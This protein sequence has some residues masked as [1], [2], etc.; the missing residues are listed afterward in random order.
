MALEL[1]I[2]LT[3]SEVDHISYL[4]WETL[5]VEQRADSFVSTASF[6][7]IDET[8]A[9]I[10]IAE[11]DSVILQ[12][13]PTKY[14]A[15]VVANID[16]VNFADGK[17][18]VLYTISCQDYN[19]LVE[20]VVIDQV[21]TY[22]GVLD[23][24]IID[25]LFD[26]YLPE[27]NSHTPGGAP[28]GYVQSLHVFPEIEFV[29]CSLREALDRIATEVETTALAG[30]W[31][32]DYDKYLHYFNEEDNSPGWGLSDTPDNVTTFDYH[33]AVARHRESSSLVNRI[34]IVGADVALLV[35]DWD[36]YYYYGKWFEAVVRD[37]TLLGV[38]DVVA[39][40]YGLLS[41]WA[42]PDEYF[43]V[44]T[45]KEGLRA[46]MNL[47]FENSL[48]GTGVRTN[49]CEN[50]SFEN[51]VVDFWNFFQAGAG[52]SAAQ[53][54]THTLRGT[55][56]CLLTAD[57]VDNSRQVTDVV[58]VADGETITVHTNI[59]REDDVS[60][61]VGLYDS[62]NAVT[63]ATE[64]AAVT[65]VWEP[66]TL[67]WT[68][69]TGLNADVKLVVW[70]L[71][72]DGA[73]A[74]WFDACVIE[75]DKGPRPIVYIDG[76]MPYCDWNGAAH[77]STS[78]RNSYYMVKQLTITW[79]DG[80]PPEP[81]FALQLG[82]QTASSSLI[83]GRLA[84][85]KYSSGIGPV[86]PGQLPICSKGWAHDLVFSATD[87]DTVEWDAGAITTADGTVYSIGAGNTGNMAA[88]TVYY[89]YLDVD[90]SEVALQ[91]TGMGPAV[92]R[93]IILVAVAFPNADAT[94]EAEFQ[95]FGGQGVNTFITAD[96]IAANTITG[97]EIAANTITA[98]NI[99]A[100]TITATEIAAETI[101]SN[102]I[103]S[104]TITAD[105]LTIGELLFSSAD[106]LLL[107]GP[108]NKIDQNYWYGTRNTL[109]TIS[110]AFHREQGRWVGTRGLVIERT[111]TNHIANPSFEVDNSEWAGQLGA[112]VARVATNPVFGTACGSAT[113]PAV[114]G[115]LIYSGPS[116]AGTFL[117]DDLV[118][119][120]VYLKWVSGT[121]QAQLGFFE[122]TAADAW[123]KTQQTAITLTSQWT[124]YTFTH[125]CDEATC[126]H[127]R[128]FIGE[129]DDTAT[130]FLMDAAQL[131]K[132][133]WPSSYCDGSLGEGY[134][135][136]G[137]AHAS[138]STRTAT[139]VNLDANI[140][141]IDGKNT[142]SH[143]LRVR[144][145]FDHDV[146]PTEAG[147]TTFFLMTYR[148]DATLDQVL[149]YY[150]TA[151]DKF[152]VNVN[153][154]ALASLESSAQTFSEGDEI[155]F[156]V[157]LDYAADDYN[158]YIDGV[159]EDN[160]TG[161]ETAPSGIDHWNLG[162]EED[163]GAFPNP[164]GGCYSEYAVFDSILSASDVGNL[165]NL[166][167]PLVDMAPTTKPGIYIYDGQFVIASSI[168]GERVEITSDGIVG[169]N[170]VEETFILNTDGSGQIGASSYEP[171]TWDTTGLIAKLKAVQM[172]IGQP[173]I[174][175]D[176]CIM[177]LGPYNLTDTD[178]WLGSRGEIATISGAFHTEQG[179]W[180]GSRALVI[181]EATTNYELAPRMLDDDSSGF[182]DGWGY[183]DN[184]GSGGSA[185]L[186]VGAHPITER[187][188]LQR[189]QYT[190]AAGDVDDQA[191]ITD[192]TS[193]GS[194][195][196]GDDVTISADLK[197]DWSG[198]NVRLWIREQG[199]AATTH[200]GPALTPSWTPKRVSFT[201]TMVD[202]GCTH[203]FAGLHIYN[204]DNGDEVDVYF[205]AVNIEKTDHPTSFCCGALDWC[206][207][208]G[209]ADASTSTR[210]ATEVNLDAYADRLAD[211]D[212]MS[213]VIWAQMPY[214]HD[215]AWPNATF[216]Y[217]MYVYD[218]GGDV[219]LILAYNAT[220]E[221]F[222]IYVDNA[223]VSNGPTETFSAGDWKLLVFTVDYAN[224]EYDLYIDGEL[225]AYS[226][227]AQASGDV[228]QWNLGSRYNA[229]YPTNSTYG[230]YAVLDRVLEP[231]EISRIWNTAQAP[232]DMGSAEKPGIYILDGRFKMASS[233]T[234][235]RIEITGDEIAGYDSAGT[236][237][238]YI[239]ASDGRGYFG[240]GDCILDEDGLLLSLGEAD[241]NKVRWGSLT[242]IYA[243]DDGVS[244]FNALASWVSE[245]AD[246]NHYGV[247]Y[248]GALGSGANNPSEVRLVSG[249]TGDNTPQID[250]LT[251][252][253]NLQ[254]VGGG[255]FAMNCDTDFY[256][257][258]TSGDIYI[259]CDDW[260]IFEVSG[261]SIDGLRPDVDETGFVGSGAI[262]W[263]DM[264]SKD[265]SDIGCLGDFSNGVKI[266]PGFSPQR[267]EDAVQLLFADE[268]EVVSALEALQRIKVS[269]KGERTMYDTP[270]LDYSTLPAAAYKPW[271]DD[272]GNFVRDR[273]SLTALISIL[274]QAVNELTDKVK[275]LEQ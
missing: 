179:Y 239:Q 145:P 67:S 59:Y 82:G 192:L 222:Q 94:K 47:E 138:T 149:L 28:P 25:D 37:N 116:A 41:K 186:T 78:Y 236:K 162:S 83:K 249:K 104:N 108:A 160:A 254:N 12:D 33:S 11:K 194:F 178:T 35:Q 115:T 154:N 124:R 153:G 216:N 30:Y 215:A 211:L 7:L 207:W 113:W 217:F 38:E 193:V 43:E 100:G 183:W 218:S 137:T 133:S 156:V 109:G 15:G 240:G 77:N 144:M 66:I 147:M 166:Q 191:L 4:V 258:V 103:A 51:N 196:Q 259:D 198:C 224:D 36:S 136:A 19:I 134:S 45:D 228:E 204:V 161:A 128:M 165:Y 201:T 123:L 263:Y 1:L 63:R 189:V 91:V 226:T 260:M 31:Y 76:T 42:F 13:G 69:D 225:G 173:I 16:S 79:P 212:T 187:G 247:I 208:S 142:V 229:I 246:G 97:N 250:I 14:F 230:Y 252:T 49:L 167:R 131:E 85:D 232:V 169:Y 148:D 130:N 181:E 244:T 235:N 175:S 73:S 238:F 101:T 34:L 203:V 143:A 71:E 88:A 139:Y 197:G 81:R 206:S 185:T 182:A 195:A 96:N 64:D 106:G 264:N 241:K 265:F 55:Q 86:E 48:F 23:S 177:L 114:N 90:T 44:S 171:I 58:T 184:F 221:E 68:N 127:V 107:F 188:W 170:D 98:G 157:T 273:A 267:A 266:G 219:R 256:F 251:D 168:S 46:G 21:E 80:C 223:W 10:Q 176:S 245:A 132:W 62:T 255:S 275:E 172:D 125:A 262:G 242:Y 87:H 20:E 261:G 151:D 214:D 74:F 152:K 5:T 84:A 52:G 141:L 17:E 248:L 56:A 119:V 272:D 163:D 164:L 274:M 200:N 129:S 271:Y 92:G 140:G 122:Y 89:I 158:L 231:D 174:D 269:T 27:I 159:L 72:G 150:N 257:D 39:H 121:K 120:S 60:A 3:G 233:A 268:G 61:R 93:N 40:G 6:Q 110:G 112:A 220:D 18:S 111:T 32:I 227:D 155:L 29:D 243:Y 117:Q 234:G 65:D 213:F 105:K 8:G 53:D 126:D 54:N 9:A 199:G 57:D 202:A 205:G 24:T 2:G 180:D 26:K 135:W 99:Q 210:T 146:A 22:G 237:Q 118:S 70:N 102:E 190:G 50:P 95:V 75:L 209:A 270:R 253:I